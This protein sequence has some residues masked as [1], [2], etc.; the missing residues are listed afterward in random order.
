MFHTRIALL[1]AL[2]GTLAGCAGN[3]K[4]VKPTTEIVDAGP[5][6]AAPVASTPEPTRDPGACRADADCAVG[7]ACTAGRCTAAPACTLLRVPFGF[8]SAQ[9]DAR[10][11]S[12]L[13]DAAACVARRRPASLLVEG[14]CDDRGTAAYN[15]ALGARRAEVVKRYLAELGVAAPIETVS[16]GEELPLAAGADD[17]A[18]AQN[19]RAEL[20]LPGETRS[21]GG[22]VAAR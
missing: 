14:H 7:E 3:A 11:T 13:G 4:A 12:A 20:R 15:V 2:G 22:S 17:K 19:R 10:A 9:L 21:D 8:D 16:F 1:A 18:W 6:A 5:A